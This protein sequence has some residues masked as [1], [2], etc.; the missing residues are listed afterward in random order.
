MDIEYV[1]L[2]K[3]IL[4]LLDDFQQKLSKQDK[5]F[6][7]FLDNI[8]P[9]E[10]LNS[11]KFY[12]VICALDNSNNKIVGYGHLERFSQGWKRHIGRLG[13]AVHT[14]YRRKGVSKQIMAKL[15]DS[16]KALGLK[17]IWLSVHTANIRAIRLYESSG[18]RAEGIF[19]CEEER[20]GK[21]LDIVSMALHIKPEIVKSKQIPWSKPYITT[22]EVKSLLD[23]VAS[24]WLSQGPQTYA[25]EKELAE[26]MGVKDVVVMNNGTSALMA[27]FYTAFKKGDKVI[28]P[29]YTFV[30]TLNSALAV[31]VEPILVDCDR[32]TGNI[33]LDEVEKILK[34]TKGI[35]GLVLADIAGLPVDMKRAISIADKFGLTIIEDAAEAIGASCYGKKIGGWGHLTSFSFH[36]AKL[37]TTIEGGAVAVGDKDLANILR[38]YRNHGESLEQKFVWEK[39]GLNCRIT[40][41]QSAIGRVQLKKLDEFVRH[42]NA[43]ANIYKKGL[44][45]LVE[46]PKVDKFVDIHPYMLFIVLVDEG[47]REKIIDKMAKENIF[48]RI[49]WRPLHK[50]PVFAD[51]FRNVSLP[52]SEQWGQRALCLPI[53]NSITYKDAER[54]VETLVDII[55]HPK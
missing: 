53:Y 41:L 49:S 33:S 40:D 37:L 31:G 24:D 17:K 25:F 4:P 55:K 13:I 3:D 6:F 14:D 28:F 2:S 10:L 30:A 20:D 51:M 54:V 7:Y 16:A 42:R 38:Q 8:K 44:S 35:K 19:S 48:C 26:Y 1:N 34:R 23:V 50:Q 15:I 12:T 5:I 22:D 47:A 21:F 11:A 52:V 39:H 32:Y 45:G 46:F 36:A 18:F 27:A 43:I 29:A 9:I